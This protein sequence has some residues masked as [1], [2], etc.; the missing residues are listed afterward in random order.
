M[1]NTCTHPKTADMHG[2]CHTELSCMSLTCSARKA[3]IGAALRL[4][5][6][7]MRTPV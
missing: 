3:L 7:D 1:H 6:S 2:V 5:V 4:T